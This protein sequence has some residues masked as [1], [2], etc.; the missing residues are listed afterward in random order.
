[1]TEAPGMN[2]RVEIARE[3]SQEFVDAFARLLPQLSSTAKPLG[4]E[5]VDGM[6]THDANT[7]LLARTQAGI[8][9][10]LTLVMLPLP[11]GL[12]A[13]VEDVVVDTA[14]RGQGVAGLLIEEALRIA[15]EAGA[16]TVDL[17]SRPDRG[18][19][20][21]LYERLGFR[22]RESTVYRF[23]LEGRTAGPTP[24]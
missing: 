20:N 12:R 9:G 7:V 2:V 19:A 17:T 24:S 23:P 16:R 6:L 13:R 11:S 10:T 4:H 8:V 1:M 3:A 22:A 21:R 5:A 18:P 15:H 14:A